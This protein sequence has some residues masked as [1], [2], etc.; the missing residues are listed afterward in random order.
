MHDAQGR[1]LRQINQA[2]RELLDDAQRAFAP[3]D[4][5][6]QIA[7]IRVRQPERE[8]VLHQSIQ[9]VPTASTP[10]VW[11]IAL[12]DFPIPRIV[13]ER[14]D[15]PVNLAFPTRARSPREEFSL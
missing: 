8:T 10:M 1:C 13:H 7:A 15:L 14:S 2:Q 12:D 11:R 6:R 4:Q 3:T 5:S 9:I